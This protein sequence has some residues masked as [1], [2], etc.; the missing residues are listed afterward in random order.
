MTAKKKSSLLLQGL[1]LQVN[2]GWR[3]QERGKEQAVILDLTL[4]FPQPPKA[5]L[6]DELEDTLCYADLIEK[7]R[8]AIA[9]KNFRLL[10]HLGY[11]IYHLIKAHVPPTTKISV[12]ITKFPKIDGLT[13]GACFCYEDD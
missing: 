6:T 12:R 2:L 10:E 11:D 13:G 4:A 8:T 3:K 7:I 5:C 9:H 1:A